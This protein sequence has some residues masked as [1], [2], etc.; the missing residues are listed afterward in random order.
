MGLRNP[1]HDIFRAACDTQTS[2]AS[3][4]E[5][6]WGLFSH[7]RAQLYIKIVL[8]FQTALN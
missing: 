4:V 3:G 5:N 6:Y 7:H 1:Y 8:S 2:P